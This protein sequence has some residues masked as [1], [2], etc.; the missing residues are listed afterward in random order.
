VSDSGAP[1]WLAKKRAEFF[2]VDEAAPAVPLGLQAA[3]LYVAGNG[4]GVAA[5]LGCGRDDGLLFVFSHDA[6]MFARTLA[7]SK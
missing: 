7:C 6:S 3:G 2:D 4:C 1:R 5:C